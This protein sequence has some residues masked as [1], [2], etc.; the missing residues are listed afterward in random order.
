MAAM[1]RTGALLER[2]NKVL[3]ENPYSP[4]RDSDSP[5]QPR[6]RAR[7]SFVPVFF[8]AGGGALH[9]LTQI[10]AHQGF[11]G[12][13]LQDS[14]LALAI[15][16][17]FAPAV[18]I[19][20]GSLNQPTVRYLVFGG[21]ACQ[22]LHRFLDIGDDLPFFSRF[23]LFDNSN[24]A[25]EILQETFGAASISL[26]VGALFFFI[27]SF[28]VSEKHLEWERDL[29][30][31]EA[32]KRQEVEKKIRQSE[33]RYDFA[34]RGSTDGLWE[35]SD[36]ENDEWWISP[37]FY[38]LLGFDDR[39]FEGT[40]KTFEAL[41]HPDDLDRA[42]EAF[43]AC[44][45]KGVPFNVEYR[46]RSK[47]GDYRWFHG[48]GATFWDSRGQ[49]MRMSGSITDIHGRK[50]T[51][52]ERDRL[53]KDLFQQ[54]KL[55]HIGEIVAGVTHHIKNIL[56]GLI[57]S[58][59]VMDLAL[60]EGDLDQA[61]QSWGIFRNTTKR[62]NT[63][64]HNLLSL[65]RNAAPLGVTVSLNAVV[66]IVIE[67]V[68]SVAN[69]QHIGFVFN[70]ARD[71]PEIR[72]DRDSLS[73]VILNLVSNAIDATS[74]SEAPCVKLETFLD[75]SK[76][77]VGLQITDNGGGIPP[78]GKEQIFEPFYSTKGGSSCG[79]GLAMVSK[80]MIEHGGKVQVDSEPGHTVFTLTFPVA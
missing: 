63:F 75:N 56:G 80:T 54:Q 65:S 37:R 13:V 52:A 42:R 26:L 45:E 40:R 77:A 51:E 70:P 21:I 79:L 3:S 76:G 17:I 61:K 32:I 74:G 18:F 28:Q 39:E 1:D 25:H 4:E 72:V 30:K 12:D 36:F 46:L 55:A 64:T 48:R 73:D 15:V 67:D 57:G 58:M 68:S 22:L 20:R 11:I 5:A 71:L 59:R 43:D 19:V 69:H 9:A 50:T 33:E 24:L 53:Q 2:R 34:V 27:R 44:F 66:E 60:A 6:R 78:D 35:W 16:L 47:Q 41:V 14:L 7:P 62:L 29:L 23:S 49:P 31:E 8:L 38:E 10:S